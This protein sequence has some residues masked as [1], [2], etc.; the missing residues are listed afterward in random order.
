[1][2]GLTKVAQMTTVATVRRTERGE[3][4]WRRV[5]AMYSRTAGWEV[6]SGRLSIVDDTVGE[7][8]RYL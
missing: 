1:M 7:E 6:S 2:P 8:R 3:R 4:T 5:S